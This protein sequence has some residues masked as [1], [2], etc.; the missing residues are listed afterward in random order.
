MAIKT[1]DKAPLFT[2]QNT[3]GDKVSL[4]DFLEEGE[5]D[6]LI[7]FF[8]LAFSGVCTDELCTIRDNM[9]LYKSLNANVLGISADSFFTLKVFKKVNNLNFPLLSDFNK[10]VSES[11]GVLYADYFGM[12]GVPK[13][14]AFI[15]GSN[16]IVKYAEVLED[17]GK[18]PDFKAI[19]KML[20]SG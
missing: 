5:S 8:P 3:S 13:R 9:K 16:G 4:K 2:L 6:T 14:S 11:Y 7:L 17:S 15:I 19:Q 12:K 10:E 18:Q 20:V 1:G